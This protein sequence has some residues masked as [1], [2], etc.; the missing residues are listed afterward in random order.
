LKFEPRLDLSIGV[1]RQTHS[2]RLANPFQPRRNVH[3]LTH[4]IAVALLDN[5]AEVNADPK[6]DLPIRLH[7]R[8][9]FDEALLHFNRAAHGVDH[10]AELDDR[11]VAG[12]L[13][14]APVMRGPRR[15]RHHKCDRW[16]DRVAIEPVSAAIL[17]SLLKT[18]CNSP[19]K[20][21][22]APGDCRRMRPP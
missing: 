11:A 5:I 4:Q 3:A 21:K 19:R 12:A 6:F 20:G 22:F 15:R 9:A 8:V 13:H 17:T 18:L 16:H 10:A 1:F 14:H 2:A 7:A